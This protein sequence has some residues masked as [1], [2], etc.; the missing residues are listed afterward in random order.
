M[1]FKRLDHVADALTAEILEVAGF[2]DLHHVILDFLRQAAFVVGLHGGGER[3]GAVVDHLGRFQDLLGGFFHA[4]DRGAEFAGG[5]RHVALLAVADEGGQFAHVVGD[6]VVQHGKLALERL[7]GAVIGLGRCDGRL[8]RLGVCGLVL[9]CGACA[10]GRRAAAEHALD[11]KYFTLHVT[12]LATPRCIL[13][14]S[15]N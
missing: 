13:Y 5:V 15:G 2:V 11:A 6:G 14:Q 10:A 4:F 9:G 12:P 3:L 1:L 8:R 7:H